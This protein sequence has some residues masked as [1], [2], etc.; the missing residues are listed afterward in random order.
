[1][2]IC[3]G[4]GAFLMEGWDT[5]KICGHDPMAV[6]ADP[7]PVAKRARVRRST[8]AAK[9]TQGTTSQPKGSRE[10][11]PSREAQRSGRAILVAA[12]AVAVA[13]AGYFAWYRPSQDDATTDAGLAASDATGAPADPA[14][15]VDTAPTAPP[16]TPVVP[17][18]DGPAGRTRDDFAGAIGGLGAAAFPLPGDAWPCAGR[19]VVDALGGAAVLAAEG[20]APADFTNGTTADRLVVPPGAIDL[21]AASIAG[22]GI[23]MADL[24][25]RQIAG[26]NDAG[27]VT[28]INAGLDRGLANRALATQLATGE[29]AM[30]PGSEFYDHLVA[31][32]TDCGG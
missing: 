8:K 32:A 1:M 19:L 16:T 31:V 17:P 4:C 25:V 11:S 20:L 9:T 26:T 29:A 24:V 3:R 27:V 14:A 28:C 6:L 10:P 5:C 22:C 18:G 23:D 30:V 15:P 2:E 21:V 12:V 13:A 7:E